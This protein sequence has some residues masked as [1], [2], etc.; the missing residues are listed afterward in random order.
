MDEVSLVDLPDGR[1]LA[2]AEYGDPG[3]TPVVACHG[4][5]G[6]R[7]TWSLCDEVARERGV[8]LL[9]PDR[10]GFGRSDVQRGRRLLDWPADVR[11]LA[12]HRGVDRFGVAG[13]SAGGPHALACA[14][15]MPDRVRGVSLVSTVTPPGTRGSA[16]PLHD[17]VLSAT[18]FVPGFSLA[19]FG[20]AAALARTSRSSLRAAI[21]GTAAAPDRDLFDG[22]RGEKLVADA[23]EGFRRG[24]RG[25]ARDLPLVGGDWGFDPREV[26][27]SVALF[28]GSADATVGPDLARAFGD[29]LPACDLHL[30][31][32]AHYSTYV[33]NRAAVVAAAAGR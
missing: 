16:A 27:L 13:F 29:L 30:G 4:V 24:G 1:D 32:G 22:P 11:A 26:S 14:H 15:A 25:P 5:L 7:L 6:S 18:R 21:V 28:H 2:Y 3:G 31:D 19:A 8:R 9:A 23:V 33:E 10:P 12:D 17:A 20:T